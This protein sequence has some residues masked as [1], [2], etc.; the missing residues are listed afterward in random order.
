MS[1]LLLWKNEYDYNVYHDSD[2]TIPTLANVNAELSAMCTAAGWTLADLGDSERG[3]AINAAV[4]NGTGYTKTL[5]INSG[6]HSSAVEKPPVRAVLDF[7]HYMASHPTKHSTTRFVVIPLRNPDGYV[8]ATRKNKNDLSDDSVSPFPRYVDLNRNFATYRGLGSASSD[9]TSAFYMGPSAASE[10]E[11]QA[12]IAALTTYAPDY[13]IGCHGVIDSILANDDRYLT[14]KTRVNNFISSNGFDAFTGGWEVCEW[15]GQESNYTRSLGIDSFTVEIG[16]GVQ[17]MESNRFISTVLGFLS[18]FANDTYSVVNDLTH[19]STALAWYQFHEG[20]NFVRDRLAYMDLA[21]VGTC[22]TDQT[23]FKGGDAS[24]KINRGDAQYIG[25]AGASIPASFPFDSTGSGREI[26]A[27]IWFRHESL[28][29]S[30]QYFALMTKYDTSNKRTFNVS[31]YNDAGTYKVRLLVGHTSGTT[32]EVVDMLTFTPSNDTWYFLTWGFK[33]SDKSWAARVYSEGANLAS[34][35]GNSTN[36]M[37]ASEAPFI[38]GGW[39]VT[40]SFAT[41]SMFDGWVDEVMLFNE[42]P[43]TAKADALWA[44]T[45]A[46]STSILIP[47]GGLTF[48]GYAPT[49]TISD[50]KS[51]PIPVGAIDITGLQPTIAATAHISVTIPAGDV[52][53]TGYAPGIS[54]SGSL[55]VEIPAGAL[56]L[57][58]NAPIVSATGSQTIT[59]PVA[60]IDITGYVPGITASDHKSATPPAAEIT[61]IGYSP[62]VACP[63]SITVPNATLSLDG[64]VPTP[65]ATAHKSITVPAGDMSFTGYVPTIAAGASIS[66][67]IPAGAIDITG[68]APYL[69]ADGD[70]L[71]EIP[72]ASI[73]FTGYAPSPKGWGITATATLR[74]V[75][76]GTDSRPVI[77][78]GADERPVRLIGSNDISTYLVS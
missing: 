60:S 32:A 25:L 70:V 67:T 69:V 23:Y 48:A 30:G 16:S 26:G 63:V 52:A 28:P 24:V 19:D 15:S 78:N 36:N 1:R 13:F 58:G 22:A 66:I 54:A 10:S 76:L 27:A 47:V 45:W 14:R 38:L 61:I 68:Y 55:S 5:L 62:S 39:F 17:H 64:F 72:S 40:G 18:S 74:L 71:I 65:T 57:T 75:L 50:H 2:E 9:P 31:I 56:D 33:D 46:P 6:T 42:I 41:T 29:T 43:S 51:I 49:I 3:E 21:N 4:I 53:L 59:V 7:L 20:S 37:Y 12:F 77:L 73:T 11:T 34:A 8:A 35:T 44:G